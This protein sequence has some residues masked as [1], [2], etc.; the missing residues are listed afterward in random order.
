MLFHARFLGDCQLLLWLVV[1]RSDVLSVAEPIDNGYLTVPTAALTSC[2]I[3][4]HFI[5]PSLDRKRGQ[6]QPLYNR[7]SASWPLAVD[8]ERPLLAKTVRFTTDHLVD[9][10]RSRQAPIGQKQPLVGGCCR[11]NAAVS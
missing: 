2:V 1:N 4:R 11:P 6:D 5:C 9:F 8:C 3:D 7:Q 10:S